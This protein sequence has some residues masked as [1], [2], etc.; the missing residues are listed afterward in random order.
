MIAAAHLR[1]IA[2][3]GVVALDA[4]LDDPARVFFASAFGVAVRRR[5]QPGCPV[6]D[7]ARTVANARRRHPLVAHSAVAPGPMEAEMLVRDS[8]CEAV[9]IGGIPMPRVVATQLI[10]FAS[11]VEELALTDDELDELISE[12]EA[13]CP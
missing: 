7:I 5:F 1:A 12:A 3:N 10:M 9:P 13:R 11:I 6:G 8:L 4:D 2:T